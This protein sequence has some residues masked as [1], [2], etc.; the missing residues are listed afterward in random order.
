MRR[1][2]QVVAGVVIG[3][4][5]ADRPP[6]GAIDVTDRPE[7]K[8]GDRYNADADV[9][10]SPPALP[11]YGKTV[12][13]RTFQFLFTATERKAIRALSSMNPD[14]EDWARLAEIPL[15]IRLKHPST[16]AGLSG[17]V[18]AGLLTE[19]RKTAISN[20]EAPS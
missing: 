14:I 18:A 20:G 8:V 9:F 4:V 1:F 3:E 12:D 19:A 17:L 6:A 11:N 16:L 7:A 2:L 5:M 10:T 13:A 15:P